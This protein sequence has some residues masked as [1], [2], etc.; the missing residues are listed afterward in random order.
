MADFEIG[1]QVIVINEADGYYGL[2]GEVDRVMEDRGSYGM[3]LRLRMLPSK[4][5][6]TTYPPVYRA[7]ELRA[8]SAVDLLGELTDG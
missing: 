7:T 5:L 3:L 8:V 6:Q 4:K 2:R 1:D